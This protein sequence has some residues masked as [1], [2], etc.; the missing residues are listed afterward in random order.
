MYML[1]VLIQSVST[2]ER[3]R[4]NWA[5]KAG[6]TFVYIGTMLTLVSRRRRKIAGRTTGGGAH[7][8]KT[9][10]LLLGAFETININ[11]M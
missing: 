4:T 11:F 1:H 7:L 3:T 5:L 9:Q 10:K 6:W 2:C 8:P